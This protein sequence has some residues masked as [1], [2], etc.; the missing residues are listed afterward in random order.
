MKE[1]EEPVVITSFK[2][3]ETITPVFVAEGKKADYEP[4]ILKYDV[5][6]NEEK[7]GFYVKMPKLELTSVALKNMADETKAYLK[8]EGYSISDDDLKCFISSL[9]SRLIYIKE[10]D[11]PEYVLK[12]AKYFTGSLYYAESPNDASIL[13]CMYSACCNPR[14]LH[15]LLWKLKPNV[16]MPEY[17]VKYINLPSSNVE[18]IMNEYINEAYVGKVRLTDNIYVFICG[19][20]NLLDERLKKQ[21]VIFNPKW[22]RTEKDNVAF[23]YISLNSLKNMYKVMDVVS[24]SLWIK[25]SQIEDIL[26]SMSVTLENKDYNHLDDY[27]VT[28]VNQGIDEDKALNYLI[29]NRLFP[30]INEK[31]L[32]ELKRRLI[33]VGIY[34]SGRENS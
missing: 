14:N 11:F 25:V 3:K 29:E 5:S 32:E 22:K 8:T 26:N 6:K 12:L 31:N 19:D 18:M 13:K 9:T 33:E 2:K 21:Y 34:T 1:K 27:L 17:L 4:V 7:K 30:M 15:F 10:N 23:K 24:D 28:L 16:P 20:I